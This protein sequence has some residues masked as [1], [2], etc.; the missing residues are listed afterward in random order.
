MEDFC[1]KLAETDWQPFYSRPRQ[2][3]MGFYMICRWYKNEKSWAML[4]VGKGDIREKLDMNF[5]GKYSQPISMYLSS[6]PKHS[7]NLL[8][9]KW[10]KD[11]FYPYEVSMEESVVY[12]DD[13][14]N[15]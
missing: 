12:S 15:H 4:C 10:M 7:R 13:G 8:W 6:F 11:P 2:F 9:I 3:I 1:D 14:V 5:A